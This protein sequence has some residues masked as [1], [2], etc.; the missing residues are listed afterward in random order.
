MNLSSLFFFH[1]LLNEEN[2]MVIKFKNDREALLIFL[3]NIRRYYWFNFK[4]QFD[5]FSN[6]VFNKFANKIRKREFQTSQTA[7]LSG[8]ININLQVDFKC[9]LI[10]HIK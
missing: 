4:I 3:T 8:K 9:N 10:V 7:R 2:S 1:L 6:F 5:Q